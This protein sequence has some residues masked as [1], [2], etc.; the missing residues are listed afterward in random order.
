MVRRWNMDCNEF[1]QRMHQRLDNRWSL[2]ADDELRRHAQRCEHCRSQLDAWHRVSSVMPPEQRVERSDPSGNDY[3]HSLLAVVGL[4]AAILWMVSVIPYV[5]NPINPRVNS[6]AIRSMDHDPT[7]LAQTATGQL[8][9]AHW[10]RSVQNR[11]WVGQT[12]PA[13]RSVQEG[14]API[15]RSLRRA[16]TIITIGGRE[17]TS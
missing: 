14:V 3:S 16:V 7:V 10:W 11:D 9:P 17:Q 6:D 15:G 8:D 4:A 13:V 5:E 2:E 12:M 1:V